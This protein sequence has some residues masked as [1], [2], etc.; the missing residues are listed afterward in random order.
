MNARRVH[1]VLR[2]ELPYAIGAVLRSREDERLA[3]DAAL[4]EREQQRRLELLWDRIHRLRDPDGGRRL[5][6]EVDR[7]R[8]A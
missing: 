4:K 8:I 6:L 2:E 7:R 1:A 5:S 3:H